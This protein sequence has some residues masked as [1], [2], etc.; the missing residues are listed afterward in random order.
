MSKGVEQQ[1][2]ELAQRY[3]G[4]DG[5]NLLEAIL[6][7]EF[8]GRVVAVKRIAE[9][10]RPEHRAPL[11]RRDPRSLARGASPLLRGHRARR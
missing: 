10:H 8:P 2:A 5:T 7:R 3:V 1:A 6:R 4:L 11:T 9:V